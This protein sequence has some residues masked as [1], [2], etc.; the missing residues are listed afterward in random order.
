MIAVAEPVSTLV[1]R[2]HVLDRSIGVRFSRTSGPSVFSTG[3]D[4]PVS[5]AWI[6][7]R[8]LAETSRA[9]PGTISPADNFTTSPGTN[10]WRGTSF[11]CPSRTTVAVTRIMALSAAAALSARVSWINLND[12]PRSTMTRIMMPV[13]TSPVTKEMTARTVSRITS[14]LRAAVQSRCPQPCCFSRP[15]SFGP[16]WI[17]RAAASSSVRPAA[18]VA[19]I[20]KTS[21]VAMRAA[22]SRRGQALRADAVR[23][24]LGV[25]GW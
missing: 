22:S 5:V 4:S 13:A 2:K 14:G 23:L 18:D 1:P 15:T 3:M 19:N 8:S 12:S 24:A 11:C 6:T 21:A 20:S 9:S 7:N 25:S 10:C 17:K 16:Y